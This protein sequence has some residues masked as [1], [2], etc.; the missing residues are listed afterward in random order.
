M[1]R[2]SRQWRALRHRPSVIYGE[3]GRG[4]TAWVPIKWGSSLEASWEL[5]PCTASG[6]CQGESLGG[7][8]G[9]SQLL[10]PWPLGRPFPPPPSTVRIFAGEALERER[11]GGFV[12]QSYASGMGFARAKVRPPRLAAGPPHR[13]PRDARLCLPGLKR[14][15]ERTE[16]RGAWAAALVG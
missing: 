3:R 16:E 14:E 2:H 7:D 9:S 4:C 1:V 12:S 11:Y 8:Q 6:N 5:R 15:R 10:P 13:H